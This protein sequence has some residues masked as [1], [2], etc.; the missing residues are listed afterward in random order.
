MPNRKPTS[1]ARDISDA[2]EVQ[3]TQ[4][5]AMAIPRP[6]RVPAEL[7]IPVTRN[8]MSSGVR[9]SALERRARKTAERLEAVT[10]GPPPKD[11]A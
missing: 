5:M 6:P 11:E 10:E 9:W 3:E 7:S 1:P 4:L 2:L 8:R